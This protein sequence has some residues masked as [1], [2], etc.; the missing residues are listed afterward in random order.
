MTA[1]L[2][3]HEAHRVST[4]RVPNAAAQLG[5]D[6][7]WWRRAGV[8]IAQN[9]WECYWVQAICDRDA[10]AARRTHAELNVL[11]AHNKLEAPTGAPEGWTRDPG[12]RSRSSRLRATAA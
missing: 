8:L 10:A 5:D 12:R 4:G 1:A 6:A 3:R 2:D 9:A 7:R 11:V